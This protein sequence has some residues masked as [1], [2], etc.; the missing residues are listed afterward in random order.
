MGG[1]VKFQF[2]TMA[3]M[4][5]FIEAKA[6]SI[7]SRVERASN[8]QKHVMRAEAHAYEQSAMIIRSASIEEFN[9]GYAY[10]TE[11]S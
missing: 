9:V 10:G 3:E 6:K 7:R 11:P 2:D 4:A 8:N 1:A 5:D